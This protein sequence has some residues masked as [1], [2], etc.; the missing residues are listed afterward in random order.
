M[1]LILALLVPA[2]NPLKSGADITNSAYLLKGALEQARSYAMANNTYVWVGFYEE[3][4]S[5]ASTIPAT[6]GTGRIVLS[7]IAS[8]DGTCVY[9]PNS[10]ANPDPIDPARVKQLNK[11]VKIENSHLQV[12]TDG[13]GTGSTFDTRP[14]PDSDPFNGSKGSKIGD[15]NTADA[16]P[17]TNSKFP[18][19]YPVG[20]P[21]LASQ[22]TFNKTLQFSPRG[23]ANINSTYSLKHIAEITMRPTRGASV[24]TNTPNV[25]AIQFSGIGGN[26]KIYRR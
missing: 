13:S 11:L 2:M 10:T 26:F 5:K 4:A 15:I 21:P 22:Y 9:D 6:A 17:P 23:E 24:D 3:D 8:I 19:Q 12:F 14:V 1:T 20:S 16:A 25:V 18:F 7:V